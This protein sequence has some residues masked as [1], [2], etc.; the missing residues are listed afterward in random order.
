VGEREEGSIGE[1]Y[2]NGEEQKEERSSRRWR[3][4]REKEGEEL[5]QLGVCI[6]R[7]QIGDV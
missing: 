7:D 2:K 6:P 4:W 1:E 5:E 3:R